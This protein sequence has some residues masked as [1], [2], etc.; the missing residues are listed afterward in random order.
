M[1]R[2][3]RLLFVLL[4]LPLTA[5]A[6]EKMP[7][8]APDALL[9]TADT[10]IV[11]G[12]TSTHAYVILNEMTLRAGV[13]VTLE[14]L[15]FDR[16][17]IYSLGLFTRVDILFD[18]LSTP[19]IL[20]VD[21]NERWHII[22]LPV[23]GFREGDIKKPY[24][25]AGVLHNNLRGRNQKLLFLLVFGYDPSAALSFHDPLFDHENRLSFSASLSYSRVRNR[26]VSQSTTTGDFTEQHY[27]V[28]LSLGKRFS[29]YTSAAMSAGVSGV[30]IDQYRVGRTASPDGTD[31]YI[32]AA[33][34]GG[35]DTRDLGEYPS[36]GMSAGFSISKLGFGESHVNFARFSA[37]LRRYIPLPADVVFATRVH[38]TLTAGGFVPSYAYQY[39]GYGERI[40][41]YYNDV[42]E[43]ENILGGTVEFRWPLFPARVFRVRGL[44]VPEE[45]SVWRFGVSLAVFA[46][47]GTVWYR[48]EPVG[49]KSFSSGYGG[50]VHFLLP[51]GAVV[52]LEGAL[53]DRG[54]AE[55][56]LDLRAAL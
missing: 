7:F 9:G 39:F 11:V 5:S 29:L 8:R 21:V 18:T 14:A 31:I 38:T 6:Q 52:R 10:V 1:S 20:L 30:H 12:N 3:A 2:T 25:G 23:F 46:N 15:Y 26:S 55:F 17:R 27:G 53:N 41:G 47:A 34:N 40:K 49:L 28:S 50:G 48:G 36:R 56:I 35:Y 13:P 32:H 24:Y 51:Y 4:S 37:D 42:F 43:G 19:R 16:N 44:P 45:F 22:P 54:R 33:V